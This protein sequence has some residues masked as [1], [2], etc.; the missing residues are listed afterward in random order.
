[1]EIKDLKLKDFT[2]GI[3][4]ENWCEFGHPDN[5]DVFEVTSKVF[6]N[7]NSILIYFRNMVERH[8]DD[9]EFYLH[10]YPEEKEG[11]ASAHIHFKANIEDD[12]WNEIK[13]PLYERMFSLVKLFNFFF[14]NSPNKDDEIFSRRH[15]EGGWC[16]LMKIKAKQFNAGRQNLALTL[17][18]GFNTIEFRYNELPKHMNQLAL[19]YYLLNIALD[20]T[21]EIPELL[22]DYEVN[23]FKIL[24]KQLGKCSFS[25][26]NKESIKRYK[27]D[28][29]KLLETFVKDVSERHKEKFYDF[30]GNKYSNF[31]DWITD[32]L[33]NDMEEF[34]KFFSDSRKEEEWSN[35]LK[36]KFCKLVKR[37]LIKI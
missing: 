29:L 32:C 26:K 23:D 12:K 4:V 20:E 17:N 25:Y 24:N 35:D 16:K 19:F 8:K 7:Y 1:M 34:K 31:N 37:E 5:D 36:K 10:S 2:F 11:S 33:K 6:N 9:S 15:S 14:K 18:D 30:N 27:M 13:Y 28:Y 21:I 22:D 3:E